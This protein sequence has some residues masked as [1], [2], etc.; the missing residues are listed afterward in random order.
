MPSGRTH[1]RI[2][3]WSLPLVTGLS[4]WQTG[5]GSL[6]LLVASGFLAGGL[7]FG[8]DLDTRSIQYKRWGWLRWIW[9]PYQ[10]Q[11]PHRS[12]LTHGPIV[13]TLLRIAYISLWGACL[14]FLSIVLWAMGQQLQ[15]T[16]DQ[17]QPL[18]Y[19]ALQSVHQ[20]LIDRLR[21]YPPGWIALGI[22]LEAGAMSHAL[23]DWI[24]STR[25]QV[26]QHGWQAL[27]PKPA[28]RKRRKR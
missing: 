1:D 21:Q 15:G 23:S 8:P 27:R 3:L 18:A 6:T 13:G 25:K 19:Q 4:F 2:T 9:I 12:L 7:V 10:Q 11:L 22:G 20:G 14:T 16:V 17:W 28:P 5:N 24:G 26:Q